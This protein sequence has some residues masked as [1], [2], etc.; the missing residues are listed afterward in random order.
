MSGRLSPH[1][2]EEAREVCETL[3]QKKGFKRFLGR[4]A[5]G[6]LVVDIKGGGGGGGAP[7]RALP[8]SGGGGGGGGGGRNMLEE[9]D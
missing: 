3:V 2:V 1:T 6:Q 9:L 7:P 4:I 5:L 8:A